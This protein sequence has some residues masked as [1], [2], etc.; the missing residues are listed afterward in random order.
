MEQFCLSFEFNEEFLILLF[1][2][3][4]A[5]EYG[6]FLGNCQRERDQ[7]FLSTRTVS[8]WTHVHSMEN[9]KNYLNPLYQIN[10]TIWPSTYSQ[11]ITL[12]S[13]LY[14]RFLKSDEPFKEA[15]SEI[16]KMVELN[17][18]AKERAERLKKFVF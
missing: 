4:Y 6:T 16:I 9:L 17:K 5:S 18:Q 11:C 8:L 12:W 15:R 7:L 13:S 14:L 3:I 2:N 10:Q 1:D